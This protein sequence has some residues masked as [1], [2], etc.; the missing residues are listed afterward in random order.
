MEKVMAALKKSGIAEKDIQTAY[1][2]IHQRNI[3]MTINRRKSPSAFRSQ[4][5]SLLKSEILKISAQLSIPL[6]PQAVTIH[7]SIT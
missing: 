6:P 5:R 7:V 4:T 1:F 3:G 2:S